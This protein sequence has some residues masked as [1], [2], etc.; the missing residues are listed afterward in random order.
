MSNRFHVLTPF[1]RPQNFGRLFECLVEQHI[2]WTLLYHAEHEEWV[3]VE[4]RAQKCAAT[5]GKFDKPFF[6]FC[7]DEDILGD[8]PYDKLNVFIRDCEVRDDTYYIC[9]CDDS[10]YPVSFFDAIANETAP[11]V[12]VSAL[13][14]DH[15]PTQGGHSTGTLAAHP[16][17]MR[18]GHVTLEQLIIRGDMFRGLNWAGG[19][20]PMAEH[21]ART[22]G[23]QIS[24]RPDVHMLFNALEPGRWEAE[25]LRRA[26]G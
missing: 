3:R 11:V 4:S 18:F 21:L 19:D 10:L 23:D 13:R 2:V 26:L 8:K 20:G 16:D 5:P 7:A 1:S 25:T 12:V 6:K 22:F 24:Y 14:G 9:L 15:T 17:N